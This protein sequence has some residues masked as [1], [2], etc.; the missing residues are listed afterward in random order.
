VFVYRKHN[1]GRP[2]NINISKTYFGNTSEVKDLVTTLINKVWKHKETENR[3]LSGNFYC[4]LVKKHLYSVYNPNNKYFS[5]PFL[6]VWNLVFILREVRNLRIFETS[7]VLRMVYGYKTEKA[8]AWWRKLRRVT[9]W[10]I[11]I[12]IFCENDQGKGDKVC[13]ECGTKEESRNIYR[14][15]IATHKRNSILEVLLVYETIILKYVLKRREKHELD[16]SISG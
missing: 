7:M 13:A 4:F 10:Y 16:S 8:T 3:I 11:L 5:P 12:A 14:N 6:G 15:L 2:Y 1:S 9:S